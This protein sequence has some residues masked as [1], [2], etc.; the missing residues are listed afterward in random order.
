MQIAKG[1][2]DGERWTRD[3]SVPTHK[4]IDSRETI[5]Y[6]YISMSKSGESLN[7]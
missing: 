4:H 6:G 3:A 5:A 7:N 2:V 1:S